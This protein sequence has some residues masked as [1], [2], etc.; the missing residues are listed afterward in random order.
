MRNYSKKQAT[1][2]CVTCMITVLCLA[3]IGFTVVSSLTKNG[4]FSLGQYGFLFDFGNIFWRLLL[5][6]LMLTIPT[7][8]L[9]IAIAVPAAYGFALLKS[10]LSNFLLFLYMVTLLMP[11]VVTLVPNYIAADWLN[12][13]GSLWAVILPS[14]FTTIGVLLLRQFIC[15]IPQSILEAAQSEGAGHSA[16]L[17][18]IVI[19]M[20]IQ[21]I[22]LLAVLVLIEQWNSV[23]LP[24]VLLQNADK[25]PLSLLL[26]GG[27]VTAKK[28][29]YAYSA[30]MM[31]VPIWLI[32]TALRRFDVEKSKD[33]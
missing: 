28:S 21:S 8:V 26:D 14:V 12:L 19:P 2:F 22:I 24:L 3:P 32:F 1:S 15:T 4:Q 27:L 20:S 31:A 10:K 11:R 18:H 16:I 29:M 30:V 6:S 9:H 7:V 23:E 33:L 17:L 25:Y 13:L 5:N